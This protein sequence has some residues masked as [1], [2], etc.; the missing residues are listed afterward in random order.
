MPGP[1]LNPAA[2]PVVVVGVQADA[3]VQLDLRRCRPPAPGDAVIAVGDRRRRGSGSS[4]AKAASWLRQDSCRSRCRRCSSHTRCR[5]AARS[6]SRRPRS[7]GLGVAQRGVR[8]DVGGRAHALPVGHRATRRGLAACSRVEAPG[9]A[10]VAVVVAGHHDRRPS[11]RAGSTRSAAAACY[12]RS[13]PR[14]GWPAAAAARRPAESATLLRSTQSAWTSPVLAPKKRSS[15]RS[16]RG[17][18]ALVAGPGRIALARVD[19]RAGQVVGEGSRLAAVAR[20]RCA[21]SRPGS[22]VAVVA[23]E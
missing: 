3:V 15:G 1:V 12:R 10:V 6:R 18:V 21:A 7:R 5:G 2:R 20:R 14:S 9:R 17:A 11:R 22:T 23:S 4:P 19:D 8:I 16:G 13:S